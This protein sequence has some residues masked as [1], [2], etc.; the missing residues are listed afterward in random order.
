MVFEYAIEPASISNWQDFRYVVDHCGVHNGR[1]I[2]EYPEKWKRVVYR[3]CKKACKEIELKRIEERLHTIGDRLCKTDRHYSETLDWLANA[4]QAH[5]AEPFHAIVSYQNPR[6][7][8]NILIAKDLSE[9]TPLWNTPRQRNVQR[10]AEPMA[11]AIGRLLQMSTEILFVDAHFDAAEERFRRPLELFLGKV[12]RGTVQKT[13]IEYHLLASG[14]LDKA[15][16]SKGCTQLLGNIIPKVLSVNFVRWK[17]FEAWEQ[18]AGGKRMHPRFI[19]TN[20]GG[21]LVEWGLDEGPD[22]DNVDMHLLEQTQYRSHWANYQRETSPFELV[23]ES[24]VVGTKES[25]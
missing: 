25:S 8:P 13:R 20:L 3:A 21:V 9:E 11:A 2:A 23:D 24:I 14:N 16:F 18:G 15:K 7:H 17:R 12:A 5:K 19:L 1:I 10:K 6:S 4:E 22:G